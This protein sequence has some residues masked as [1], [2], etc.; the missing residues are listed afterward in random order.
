VSRGG[1]QRREAQATQTGGIGPQR[2]GREDTPA[3]HSLSRK[4]GFAPSPAG[5]HARQLGAVAV[6]RA[7]RRWRCWAAPRALQ[8]LAGPGRRS[9]AWPPST[10]A[11]P[12]RLACAWWTG[13]RS[14][15]SS[16]RRGGGL[17]TFCTGG[18]ASASFAG[19]PP[20]AQLHV[21]PPRPGRRTPPPLAGGL[22][23][24]VCGGPVPAPRGGLVNTPAARPRAGT[25]A[26]LALAGGSATGL[27]TCRELCLTPRFPG[28]SLCVDSAQPGKL[29]VLV[30]VRPRNA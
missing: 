22:R 28:A 9:A 27:L 13:T 25:Y 29:H 8:G 21:G 26:S 5:P 30:T 19:P 12:G 24:A 20:H 3:L 15:A 1:A 23:G 11:A 14:A 16:S 2:Q 17:C 10:Q 4:R 7:K 18:P 6:P